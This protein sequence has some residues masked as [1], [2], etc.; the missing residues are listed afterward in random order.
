MKHPVATNNVET[1]GTIYAR[2]FRSFAKISWE[3][4][5]IIVIRHAHGA[6]THVHVSKN[7]TEAMCYSSLARK[8]IDVSKVL[9]QIRYQPKDSTMMIGFNLNL[10]WSPTRPT[11]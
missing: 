3:R 2:K 5:L 9:G 1:S 11:S 8:K 7:R 4:N 6:H 10:T